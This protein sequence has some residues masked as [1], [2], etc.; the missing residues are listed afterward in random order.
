MAG[1]VK[2]GEVD[3]DRGLRGGRMEGTALRLRL[4]L[5]T[6]DVHRFVADS[7]HPMAVS[8][9]SVACAAFG[10]ARPV[11][12]GTCNILVDTDVPRSK[13]LRYRLRFEDADGRPFTLSGHKDV[14]DDPGFDLW[15]DTTTLYT[16]I[17]AG[18]VEPADEDRTEVVAAGIVRLSFTAFL[19]QLTTFRAEGGTAPRRLTGLVRFVRFFLGG[20]WEVYGLRR[21]GRSDRRRPRPAATREFALHTLEGVRDAHVSTHY[22]TTD[23]RLGLSLLRFERARCDDVVLLVH[24]LT[25]SSDMFMM[26]EHV[27]LVSYLLDKGFT[28]VWSFDNRMSNRHSYNLHRHRYNFDDVALFDYPAA[29]RAMRA[30]IGDRRVHVIC[31]CLG[32]MTFMMSLFGGAVG[33]IASVVSNSVALTPRIPRWA[34]IKLAVAPFLVEYVMSL[35]YVD[36]GASEDPGLAPG[37]LLARAVSLFHPE[38]D[39]PACHMLSM[40]WGSGC[41][42]LYEHANLDERTHRRVRDLFGGTS[43]HYYRHIRKMVRAYNTAV[44]FAP[45]DPR[46]AELP[47][48]YLTYAP[49]IET[50][51]LFLSGDRNRVFMNS[52]VLCY[53]RL[54]DVAPRRHE[55]A[56]LEGYGHQDVFMGKRVHVDVFPR[57]LAF[58]RR[59]QAAAPAV[60][61]A[62]LEPA[63]QAG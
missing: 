45:A 1:F 63:R 48:D 34:R 19:R 24:G 26:P 31:H 6:G 3:Y 2:L 38:C 42:A 5:S 62:P 58:L 55:L 51:I 18:D 14:Q 13:Q 15:R 43:V 33:N 27:N 53:R 28:D 7:A 23:D 41:P 4:T 39:V 12:A 29:L 54:E 9:G 35:P 11:D 8:G 20:L 44:K 40:M 59:H 22:V 17:F 21:R 10:G 57:I 36:P 25:S 16:R 49:Q 56:I 32:S 37:E 61:G 52:N 50:P 30:H 60:E 47:D 46:Y